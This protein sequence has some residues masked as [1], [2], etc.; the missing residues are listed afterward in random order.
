MKTIPIGALLALLLASVR[1]DEPSSTAPSEDEW[2]TFPSYQKVEYDQP[3]RPQFHF[4]SRKNWLNDP[5]GMV[6]H[7]GE[8]IMCFQHVANK[9]DTG[10][11]SW[12]AAAS[13]DL[14]HWEQLPHAINPYPNVM[15]DEGEPHAIW[16]GSAVVDIHNALGKQDG[17][18]KTL[19]ALYSATHREPD[20]QAAFFQ[21]GA[22]STDNG[23]SWTKID[24]GRPVIAHQPDGGG[25]QRD[26]RAFYFPPEDC[27]ITIMMIGGEDRAVRLWKSKDLLNWEPFLDIPNKAAECIDMYS[28][29]IDGDSE[30]RKWVIADAATRYEVGEFDGENW[31]GLGDSDADGVRLKFDYGDAYYAA[32]AFNQAPEGRVVHVGWLRSKQPG[33]RPFLEAGMPFTQQMSIPAEITLRSTPDGIRMFRNPVQE[34]ESL[35]SKTNRFENLTAKAAN[36]KLSQLDPELI[37]MT[38]DFVPSENFTL[39]VRGL[40]ID[41]D[42]TTQEFVFTNKARVEGEKAAWNKRGPYRDDGVRRIPAPA[43]DG[44]VQLRALVDRASLELFINTGQAAASFVV[45]PDPENRSITIKNNDSLQIKSLVVNELKSIWNKYNNKPK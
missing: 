8:W 20:N 42:A 22:Y 45:V 36:A 19:F 14:I 15:W 43:V 16:S 31:T 40:K 24:E 44:T 37:D 2:A 7:D 38:L 30:N 41:Y 35:Y 29:A 18:V 33:Y 4:T 21:G 9:N 6:Y 1:A 26:P 34:I 12:G 27:F 23:R 13:T 3:L 32:Q 5:N 28:V 11:K 25:G 10:M 17:D 39:D